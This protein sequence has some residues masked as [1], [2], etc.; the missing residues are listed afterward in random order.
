M[1]GLPITGHNFLAYLNHL[2][3]RKNI[4]NHGLT[5]SNA[6]KEANAQYNKEHFKVSSLP[7]AAISGF[8]RIQDAAIAMVFIAAA[9]VIYIQIRRPRGVERELVRVAAVVGIGLAGY[10]FTFH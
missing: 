8:Q 2:G 3:A 10:Y 6:N 4:D 9:A 7:S 1:T 5:G